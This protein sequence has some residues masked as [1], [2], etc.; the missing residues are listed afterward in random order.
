VREA[1]REKGIFVVRIWESD[2]P[3][4]PKCDMSTRPCNL[5]LLPLLFQSHFPTPPHSGLKEVNRTQIQTAKESKVS[6]LNEN[7]F[8]V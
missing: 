2:D 3:S 8:S 4:P 7:P 1:G 5:D 6:K